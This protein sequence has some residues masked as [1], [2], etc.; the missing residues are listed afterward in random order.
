MLKPRKEK[1]D[2]NRYQILMLKNWHR[3]MIDLKGPQFKLRRRKGKAQ[4]DYPLTGTDQEVSEIKE[5]LPMLQ[6]VLAV[7]ARSVLQHHK[8]TESSVLNSNGID[9]FYEFLI[10]IKVQLID[11]HTAALLG[12]DLTSLNKAVKWK[13]N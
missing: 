5:F 6:V 13:K 1:G 11:N 8:W 3:F 2:I 7:L 12:W 4:N 10:Y 9:Q